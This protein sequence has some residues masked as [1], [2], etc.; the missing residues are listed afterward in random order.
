MSAY[1]RQPVPIKTTTVRGVARAKGL[2]FES[3]S[4]PE[5]VYALGNRNRLLHVLA[6]P[7]YR[8]IL[9]SRVL[10]LADRGRRSISVTVLVCSEAE[11]EER[12]GG[13][14]ASR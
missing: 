5:G 4:P 1:A 12:S 6:I 3:D 9:P 10:E 8:T 14:S 7:S 11:R 13:Q 2:R